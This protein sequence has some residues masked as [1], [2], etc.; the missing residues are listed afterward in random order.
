MEKEVKKIAKPERRELEII[1]LNDP[2]SLAEF[3]EQPKIKIAEAITG[4]L[5]AGVPGLIVAGARIVQ[6]AIKGD[7]LRQIGR[8]INVLVEKGKIKEDYVAQ[9]Y[10]FQSLRDILEFIDSEAPD[11]ERFLAVKAM[12]FAVN[13]VDAVEGE[14]LLNYELFQITKKLT[15][16][17]LL[18]LKVSYEIR[19]KGEQ[20]DSSAEAWLKFIAERVGHN[21]A[22]LIEK[23]ESVLIDHRLLTIRVYNDQSGIRGGKGGRLTD[24]AVKL[25]ENLEK[26][27]ALKI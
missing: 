26:Y 4:G 9:K 8:E 24:L 21:V 17:Q 19:K 16:S 15:G 3:L 13:S 6:G 2:K 22:S 27:E 7:M 1:P 12:F 10:G 5:E 25:C 23:D 20:L 11:Q 14:A 18:I